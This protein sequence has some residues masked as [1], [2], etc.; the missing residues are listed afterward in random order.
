MSGGSF[1]WNQYRINDIIEYLQEEIDRNGKEIPI[2]ERTMSQEYYNKY[3]EEGFYTEHSEKVLE[4]MKKA[5][6]KLKE[7][8]IFAQR[9]DWYL[10]S[11]DGEESLIRRLNEELK[12]LEI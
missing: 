11:D 1:E 10:S 6:G 4:I 2:E 12:D 7:S 3:P 5:I 8:F 9:L